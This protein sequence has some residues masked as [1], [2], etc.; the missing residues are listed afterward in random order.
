MIMLNNLYQYKV[1]SLRKS[2]YKQDLFHIQM[3]SNR[4]ANEKREK[5]KKKE[6]TL[7]GLGGCGKLCKNEQE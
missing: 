5:K 7:L 2:L 1:N 6:E 4:A 3:T